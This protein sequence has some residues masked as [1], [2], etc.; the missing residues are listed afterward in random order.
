MTLAELV[1]VQPGKLM[2]G[3]CRPGSGFATV[4]FAILFLQ[5]KLSLFAIYSWLLCLP[6]AICDCLSENPPSLHLL[7]FREI[8]F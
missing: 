6:V 1:M 8:P 2:V 7:V 3:H 5:P 4:Y